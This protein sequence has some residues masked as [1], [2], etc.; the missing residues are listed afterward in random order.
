MAVVGTLLV[1]PCTGVADALILPPDPP[2]AG[3]AGLAWVGVE[4]GG[5]ELLPD[6]AGSLFWSTPASVMM[7][8]I[9]AC[10]SSEF[11]RAFSSASLRA[12]WLG[13]R[14]FSSPVTLCR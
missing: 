10:S 12:A 7:P 1:G 11:R 3:V 9:L 4:T 14:V 8:W 2:A 13:A 5:A 6:C